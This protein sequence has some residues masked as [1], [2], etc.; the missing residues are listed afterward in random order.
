MSAITVESSNIQGRWGQIT[1]DGDSAVTADPF[2]VETVHGTPNE[3][4]AKFATRSKADWNGERADAER[5]AAARERRENEVAMMQLRGD[6][7]PTS[8]DVF[9]RALAISEAQD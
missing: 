9:R 8:A 2:D 4:I 6:P 3:V 7:V 1:A 5:A